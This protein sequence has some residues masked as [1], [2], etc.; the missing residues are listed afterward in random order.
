MKERRID[1]DHSTIVVWRNLFMTFITDVTTERYKILWEEWI[2]LLEKVGFLN[3]KNKCEFVL[4]PIEKGDLT[5]SKFEIPEEV[6]KLYSIYNI[7]PNKDEWTFSLGADGYFDL[8]SFEG[9]SEAW[10]D[11]ND[12]IVD[13]E[14][15][16]MGS[17]DEDIGQTID[18]E[19]DGQNC[20]ARREWIPIA[21]DRQGNYLLIDLVPTPK[22]KK[23]QIISICNESW[24]RL[25][26]ANSVYDLINDRLNY[27]RNLNKNK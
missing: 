2:Y 21:T 24:D 10:E 13:A 9:I 20:Y 4:E 23:G 12:L 26:I 16:V 25:L 6:V 7:N 11:I 14:E 15:G 27:L 19:V 22:G 8:L 3:E 17:L 5:S 18:E 1:I